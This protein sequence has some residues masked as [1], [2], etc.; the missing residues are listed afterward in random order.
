MPYKL[1]VV[2][3]AELYILLS[4]EVKGLPIFWSFPSDRMLPLSVYG[5]KNES[6]R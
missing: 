6:F 2:H 1:V 4:E 5:K 3:L